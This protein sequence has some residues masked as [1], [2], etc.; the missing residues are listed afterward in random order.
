M[1]IV[2][3]AI[4][5]IKLSVCGWRAIYRGATRTR[6]EYRPY[7]ALL[8]LSGA[9]L[10]LIAV[11]ADI[12]N[13]VGWSDPDRLYPTILSVGWVVVLL[14]WHVRSEPARARAD[15]RVRDRCRGRVTRQTT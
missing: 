5:L 11:V 6:G 10:V 3:S 15:R 2:L 13:A 1:S 8:W 7:D 9:V 12:T 14:A 4:Y